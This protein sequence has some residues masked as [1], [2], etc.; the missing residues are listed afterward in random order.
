MALVPK[1]SVTLNNKCN[2]AT[3]TEETGLYVLGANDGGWGGIN[4]TTDDT[5]DANLEIFDLEGSL[6]QEV[7]VYPVFAGLPSAPTP[8]AFIVSDDVPWENADGIYELVYTVTTEEL[9]YTNEK[10]HEL[11]ICNL[12]NCMQDLITKMLNACDSPTVD[13]LKTQVDQMEVF[14][15]GIQSAFSCGDFDTATS[16]LESAT[17]YCQT[18]S[19]CGCGCGGC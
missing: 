15:Y 1:I 17:V 12:C 5:T 6:L 8:G 13:K 4:I 10:Q 2:S 7:S 18:L 11:F 14:I 16:I 19:D 3:V 9:T